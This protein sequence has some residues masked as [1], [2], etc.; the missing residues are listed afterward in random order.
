M[1]TLII[2]VIANSLYSR[3]T[4]VSNHFYQERYC[5]QDVFKVEQLFQKQPLPLLMVLRHFESP[6]SLE[7][8]S[9][10]QGRLLPSS[11]L[12]LSSVIKDLLIRRFKTHPCHLAMQCLGFS[13]PFS[14]CFSLASLT[15]VFYQLT[16][17]F[18]QIYL[19][20][21]KRE[22]LCSQSLN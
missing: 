7:T 16:H 15:N 6:L 3:S 22:C 21:R 11:V 19:K 2:E 4:A 14:L 17:T 12:L 13:F 5:T 20:M 1:F 9:D 18:C 8:Y 10:C